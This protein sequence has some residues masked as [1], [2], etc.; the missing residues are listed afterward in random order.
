MLNAGR[1][2]DARG[3]V[4]VLD[5]LLAE[6]NKP[7][8]IRLDNGPEL[9]A[10]V[11]EDWCEEVPLVSRCHIVSSMECATATAALLGPLRLAIRAYWVE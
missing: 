6:R 8:F 2:M 11:L 7:C 1:S 3:V 4:A 9:I 10:T 5:G